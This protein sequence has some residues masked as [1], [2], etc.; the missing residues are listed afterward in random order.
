MALYNV[1]YE[2]GFAVLFTTVEGPEDPENYDEIV[3]IANDIVSEQLGFG[4]SQSANYI[5]VEELE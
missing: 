4:I 3:D 1:T 5:N 2:L